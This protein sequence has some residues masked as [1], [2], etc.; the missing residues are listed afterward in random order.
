MAWSELHKEGLQH[1]LELMKGS[2]SPQ[3]SYYVGLCT[4][5]SLAEDATLASITEVSGTGYARQAAA[6]SGATSEG[7]G[8]NDWHLVLPQ[9]TF[10]GG[11][12]GWTGA[13]GYFVA[14]VDSGTSGKL[15]ASGNLAATRTLQSGDTEKVTATILLT[16]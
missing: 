3:A 12:G 1:L 2:Q 7:A 10:T 11:A 4:D 13:T 6:M 9:V 16:G 14:T 15:I 5:A 8:T